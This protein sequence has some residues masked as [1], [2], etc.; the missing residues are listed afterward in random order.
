M[1]IRSILAAI[2][3]VI[4]MV[5]GIYLILQFTDATFSDYFSALLFQNDAHPLRCFL[6]AFGAI[7]CAILALVSCV[8]AYFEDEHFDEYEHDEFPIGAIPFFIVA[9]LGLFF[10]ALGCSAD[11][12]SAEPFA[13]E[14]VEIEPAMTKVPEPLLDALV[15][16]EPE[17]VEQIDLGPPPLPEIPQPE[18]HGL[19]GAGS[20]P[21][22]LPLVR[23]DQPVESPELTDFLNNDVFPFGD[24]AGG[25]RSILCGKAWV[26]IVGSASEEGPSDRNMK[27]AR[28]RA[29]LALKRAE[30]WLDHHEDSCRRPVLL[31]VDQGQ[32]RPTTEG[33]IEGPE[34]SISRTQ[35]ALNFYLRPHYPG[36]GS[37]S[38]TEAMEELRAYL[39]HRWA[40]P[41]LTVSDRLYNKKPEAF[42][43]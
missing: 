18:V 5:G 3:T 28:F 42:T 33:P 13:D 23:N 41:G 10:F 25:V 2:I 17:T 24:R 37:L 35:R 4:L 1:T 12:S 19:F 34:S 39:D 29:E 43:R 8:A 22:K 32:H 11:R 36:E 9:S 30:E 20:W 14:T 16:P 40:L 15:E 38:K 31:G 6:F 26:A 21:Y 7:V 27:R